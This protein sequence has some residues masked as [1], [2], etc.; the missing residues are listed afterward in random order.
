MAEAKLSKPMQ[1]LADAI[2][3]ARQPPKTALCGF[4]LWLE[5][6]ASPHVAF[7]DLLKGGVPAKGDEP[8]ELLKVP[9]PMLGRRIVVSLDVS[10][11]PDGFEL[12]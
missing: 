7:R 2:R 3:A 10:L 6:L 11:P 5:V 12:R 8:P 4:D 1:R 9:V